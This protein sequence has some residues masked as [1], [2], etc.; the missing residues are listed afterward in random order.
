MFPEKTRKARIDGRPDV[1]GE[2]LTSL[3]TIYHMLLIM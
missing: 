1:I 3:L 2:R